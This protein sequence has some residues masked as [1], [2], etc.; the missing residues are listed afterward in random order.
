VGPAVENPATDAAIGR[1]AAYLEGGAERARHEGGPVRE[2]RERLDELRAQ[3]YLPGLEALAGIAAE[4]PGLLFDHARDMVLVVDEPERVEDELVRAAHE[5][6]SAHEESGERILPPPDRLFAHTATV[7]E[8]LRSGHLVLQ[9]LMGS[10]PSSAAAVFEIPSRTVPSYSGR[11]GA[12]TEDIRGAL[13]RG[14]RVLCSMRAPGGA[15]R[16]GEILREHGLDAA[17]AGPAGYSGDAFSPGGLFVL[18]GALRAGFELPNEGLLV[19]TEREIFGDEAKS[20]ERKTRGRAAFLSDFRDLKIGDF[21][22]HVDHGIARYRGLGRPKGGSL[23]RD[24]MVLEFAGGDRLFVP[25]DRLN[26]VQRYSGVAAHRPVLDKLG[27]GGW[28]RV[29]ARVRKSVESLA[30]EMLELYAKRKAARGFA[31]SPDTPW[32]AE[33]EAAFPF[34][35]TVDQERA[36]GEVK[37]D[38]ES[39]RPMDRLLVG[40]VGFGKTEVAVRAAFKAVMDGR[41]VAFLAPT[42]V[43]AMQHFNTFRERYAPFPVRVEMVSR[44]RT[45]QRLKL[46]IDGLASAEVDVVIGTHRLLSKDVR[47]KRLGLL[48]IDEEQRF[49]VVHKERIKKLSL[50]VDVLAMTATP[51]PR[52][53][54]MSLAGVRDLSIIETPPAGRTAIQTY[55]LS[56]RKNVVAQAIRHELRRAGQ[57]F[58]VHDRVETLPALARAIREMTPDARVVVAHGTSARHEPFGPPSASRGEF[59]GFFLLLA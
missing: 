11:I 39:E 15:T 22:V 54:Q 41:Q 44:F 8:R 18:V 57:V 3:G 7:I 19:L 12:G 17:S 4:R 47:F 13:V 43:L 29:K 25:V 28:D 10:A 26:L 42:T 27:G 6:R 36:I 2:F 53:L 31:F 24:F 9:E 21:V 56:F 14:T 30:R 46:V 48:I 1:L 55:L 38:M 32:Q 51:I 16:L 45:P 50:G 23:N 49:G 58:V 34:E 35:L 20:A 52:T 37:L 5:I 33:L 40:D 59:M